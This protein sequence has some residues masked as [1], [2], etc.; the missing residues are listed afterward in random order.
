MKG[1]LLTAA[2]S[3]AAIAIP[4]PGSAQSFAAAG[5]SSSSGSSRIHSL[6]GNPPPRAGIGRMHG[7]SR[8]IHVGDGDGGGFGDGRRDRGDGFGDGFGYGVGYNDYGDYDGNRQ[9]DP[10]KWNDW[11]HNRPD[12]AFPR[13]V[14][15]NQNC[16][17]DRMWS[18][19]SGWR[20]TP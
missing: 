5:F 13:W 10:D 17:P 3:I 15:N 8:H 2:A 12:R 1:A 6:R 18:S 14:W 19:G 16:T 11:W 7:H 20:C 9:F 4:S